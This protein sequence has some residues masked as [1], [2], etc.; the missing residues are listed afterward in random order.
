MPL[1]I[2]FDRDTL[3]MLGATLLPLL[4]V[5][6]AGWSPYALLAFYWF[7]TF[8]IGIWMLIF[9]LASPRQP[10]GLLS[11]P[12]QPMHSG[13]GLALFV[14]A[15]A[16]MFMGVHLF[17]LYNVFGEGFIRPGDG[18]VESLLG[19]LFDEGLWLP[20]LG[21]FLVRGLVTVDA[22]R[23]QE[24]IDRHLIGFYYRIVVMQLAIIF[25]GMFAL[26]LG[27]LA[28]VI[29]LLAV[30][31]AFELSIPSVED[32]VEAHFAKLKQDISKRRGSGA[33]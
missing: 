23:H 30:R 19:L 17:F 10:V 28:G 4:G 15:H 9:I 2:R 29:T 11:N 13:P 18:L 5:I 14:L 3:L 16:G 24:R 8:V 33:K 32:Y 21:F 25:G 1:N 26:V 31:V 12:N 6:F 27:P 7:E 20:L 22:L